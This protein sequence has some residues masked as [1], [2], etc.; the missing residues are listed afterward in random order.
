MH[1]ARDAAFEAAGIA[2]CCS[3]M[4]WMHKHGLACPS[5]L[6]P[7]TC[8]SPTP[9]GCAQPA[10][11]VVGAMSLGTGIV[12][13][14]YAFIN[15]GRRWVPRGVLTRA[16]ACAQHLCRRHATRQNCYML[17]LFC[18]ARNLGTLMHGREPCHAIRASY[19]ML[20]SPNPPSWCL[21]QRYQCIAPWGHATPRTLS[22][23]PPI[24]VGCM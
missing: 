4:Y 5:P 6:I 3:N 19:G 18:V 13:I 21:S 22:S 20:S 16:P 8:W 14:V 15:L 17:D 7:H 24:S 11:D 9:A 10:I 2:C 23:C 12:F 1:H